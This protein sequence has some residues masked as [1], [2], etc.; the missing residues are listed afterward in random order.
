[1]TS[2]RSFA[3]EPTSV[4]AARRFATDALPQLPREGLEAIVLMVSEL[5]SNCIRFT[6]GGFSVSIED[7][8]RRVRVD[9]TDSGGGEPTIRSPRPT[10]LSGRGLRIVEAM[11]DDWGVIPAES[12]AGT[13]VWFTLMR[14]GGARL[15]GEDCGLQLHAD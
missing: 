5:A 13:T 14:G 4:G 7:D 1:M 10:D 9:V 8:S 11:S 6:P 15:G 3:A 12:S 2:T